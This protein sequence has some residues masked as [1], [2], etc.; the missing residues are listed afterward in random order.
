MTEYPTIEATMSDAHAVLAAVCAA[1]TLRDETSKEHKATWGQF[2]T[3]L[4]I[5]TFMADW[6]D[7]PRRAVRILD[8]G[9]GTGVLGICAAQHALR[10]G[11]PA[12][13]LVAVERE[14]LAVARLREALQAAAASLGP[15]FTFD[16]VESDA[17]DLAT[18]LLGSAA[19]APFDVA[20]S[21]PPYFKMSP[22]DPRGGGAPNAYARFMEVGS[23]LLRTGGQL[24][25]I[26]PRSFASGLY[27]KGFRKDFHARMDLERVHAF[28]SRKDAF[29]CHEVLQENV[30]VAYRKGRSASSEVAVTS[31]HGVADLGGARPRQHPRHTLLR[32]TDP[33]SVLFL[34]TSEADVAVMRT[35]FS[36]PRRLHSLKLEVSTGPVVPFRTEDL[37]SGDT[38]TTVPLLWL[39]HIVDGGVTW[40]LPGGF[41]KDEHIEAAAGP[42][43]LVPN[44]TYILIRRFSAKEDPRRLMLGV[45]RRG[46]LPG[47]MVGLENHVNFIHRPCG[48]LDDE[49]ATGLAAVLLSTIVDDFFRIQSGN[50]QVSATELRALP[51]PEETALRTIGK[52]ILAE[53]PTGLADHA[54]V[55]RV[56]EDHLA[57]PNRGRTHDRS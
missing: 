47:R 21:N 52:T 28:D 33:H 32:P 57:L 17:L 51:L 20:I 2:F 50:T 6:I 15:E 10:S 3:P 49:L 29:R 54:Q 4:P 5:G 36:W 43:L 27:F 46:D 18:P 39:Q 45:L 37:R 23:V 19:L 9:A 14:P 55:D 34:P 1:N 44:D 24:I 12:A 53:G 40:P 26:V 22:S 41:R 31:S 56:V 25:Y 11:A 48:Q 8:L 13:H 38:G 30:I 35:I 7:V 16:L 42:K